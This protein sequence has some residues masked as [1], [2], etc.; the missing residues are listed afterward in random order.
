M[1]SFLPDPASS[2][3]GQSLHFLG[4]KLA[5]ASRFVALVPFLAAPRITGRL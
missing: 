3:K 5:G 1:L 4:A 2:D